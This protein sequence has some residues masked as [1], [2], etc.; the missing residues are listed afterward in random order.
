MKALELSSKFMLGSL[1]LQTPSAHVLDVLTV[2]AD[3]ETPMWTFSP[4]ERPSYATL[5]IQLSSNSA[6]G[7]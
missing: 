5:V 7:G 3:S 2:P 6:C 1:G 4:A